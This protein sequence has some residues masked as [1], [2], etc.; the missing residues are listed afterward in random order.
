MM[1][2]SLKKH[3]RGPWILYIPWDY[4]IRLNEDYHIGTGDYPVAGS[5]RSRLMELPGLLS[6]RVSHYMPS[7][8]AV[9]V[10]MTNSTVMLINA[11][12]MQAVAWEP[13]GVPYWNHKFKVMTMAV[14]MMMDDYDQN[15]GIVL[16]TV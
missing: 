8:T 15:C 11:M 1:A 6:I 16:G 3:H 9:L 5:I 4:Q 2:E 13:P 10:E 7:N 12:D 14:P